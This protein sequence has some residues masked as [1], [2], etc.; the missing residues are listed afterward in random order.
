MMRKGSAAARGLL[1][2]EKPLHHPPLGSGS[3]GAEQETATVGVHTD[4]ETEEVALKPEWSHLLG[5]DVDSFQAG[6]GVPR[7]LSRTE[8]S[9]TEETLAVR[10]PRARD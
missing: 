1:G 3:P 9:K 10:R 8:K 7:D 5:C 2:T 6:V 4:V